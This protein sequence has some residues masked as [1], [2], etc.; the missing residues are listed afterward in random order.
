MCYQNKIQVVQALDIKYDFLQRCE[1][2]SIK[3]FEVSIR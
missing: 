2:S 1:A 3:K